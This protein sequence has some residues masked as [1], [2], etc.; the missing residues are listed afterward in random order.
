MV[1][2]SRGLGRDQRRSKKKGRRPLRRT[3]TPANNVAMNAPED[4]RVKKEQQQQQEQQS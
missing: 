3:K 4:S 1:I 2:V